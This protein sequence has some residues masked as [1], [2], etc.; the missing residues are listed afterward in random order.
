MTTAVVS[1]MIYLFSK[2]TIIVSSVHII[3]SSEVDEF[4]VSSVNDEY[5]SVTFVK[6]EYLFLG[7]QVESIY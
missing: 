5:G 7:Y 4:Y 2:F 1:H 3:L 6:R